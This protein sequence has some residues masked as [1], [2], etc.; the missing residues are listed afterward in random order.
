MGTGG[1]MMGRVRLVRSGRLTMATF[2]DELL[3][4]SSIE[5]PEDAPPAA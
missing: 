4:V 1:A 5:G 3:A 2:L